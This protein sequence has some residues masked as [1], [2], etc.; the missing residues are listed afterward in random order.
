MT[1]KKKDE[2]GSPVDQVIASLGSLEGDALPD[3]LRGMSADQLTGFVSVLDAHLRD[4]HQDE[5]GGLREKSPEQ[6]KAFSI[7]L[8]LRDKVMARIEDD[9]KVAAIFANRPASVINVVNA[10]RTGI[11]DESGD[12]RRLSNQQAR[13][14]AMRRI[15]TDRVA[16]AHLSD[17]QKTHIEAQMRKDPLIA[18]RILVTE[19]EAYR[20][21]WMKLVTDPD[22]LGMLTD[23]EKTAVRAWKQF[24]NL[25]E[26]TTTAGGFGIPVKLAA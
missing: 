12:T 11:E 14:A 24:K 4:L 1:G 13:D 21:A 19:N 9:R 26:N 22:A 7:G 16:T 20:A 18:R 25:S 8:D 17:A 23:E 3:G 10:I 2:G 6:A 15:D 5:F